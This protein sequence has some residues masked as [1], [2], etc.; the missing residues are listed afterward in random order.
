L[1]RSGALS[2]VYRFPSGA[3]NP[4]GNS[5]NLRKFAAHPKVLCVTEG[6]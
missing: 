5:V 1:G 3:E 6:K 2:K 4:S